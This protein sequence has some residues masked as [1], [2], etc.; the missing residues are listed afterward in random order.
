MIK[1]FAIFRTLG[2]DKSLVNI[3]EAWHLSKSWHYSGGFALTK[4]LAMF[5]RL[6]IDQRHYLG[7]LALIKILTIFRR[8]GIDQKLGNIQEAWH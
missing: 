6:G 7:G 3:Q 2:I 5:R 8:L 1:V 4:V